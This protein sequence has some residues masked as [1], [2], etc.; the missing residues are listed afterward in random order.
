MPRKAKTL[1][2]ADGE[3]TIS[4]R[5]DANGKTIGYKGAVSVGYKVD[6]TEDR[7]WVSGKTEAAVREKLEA[8]KNARN[9]GMVSGDAKLSLSEYLTKWLAFKES[10][11]TKP[12][13]HAEYSRLVKRQIVPVLGKFKLEKLR[14]L[15][16]QN[17]L[18]SIKISSTII[19]TRPRNSFSRLESGCAPGDSSPERL[20]CCQGTGTA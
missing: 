8:I 15:D 19:E 17:A 13:T 11:G 20:P 5:L 1:K 7:R 6:G 2:R 12:K 9:T 18:T 14:P 4:K 10:D 3:G 16:V